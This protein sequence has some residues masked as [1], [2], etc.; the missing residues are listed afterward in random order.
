[1][2]WKAGRAQTVM[3]AACCSC[4][5][6]VLDYELMDPKRI[7]VLKD[8]VIA[9][10]TALAR[11]EHSE[12]QRSTMRL[13]RI[14]VKGTLNSMKPGNLI[15]SSAAKCNVILLTKSDDIPYAQIDLGN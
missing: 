8:D 12:T 1:M 2:V 15:V 3:R 11:D 13:T 5:A 10:L 7:S 14:L 9:K 4:L 6:V